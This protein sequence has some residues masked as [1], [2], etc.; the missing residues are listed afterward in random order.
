MKVTYLDQGGLGT[1]D[2]HCSPYITK[3]GRSRR[4]ISR[5]KNYENMKR[6]TG[7]HES[8]NLP[9]IRLSWM[10]Q[11][12]GSSLRSEML[13]VRR[14]TYNDK[15]CLSVVQCSLSIL[16]TNDWHLITSLKRF[17]LWAIITQSIVVLLPALSSRLAM[18]RCDHHC[19]SEK[20]PGFI[21]FKQCSR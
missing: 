8:L 9:S 7:Y 4:A 21:A 3:L 14:F 6:S 5:N 13:E 20:M 2:A 10:M 16:F 17:P 15:S 1:W 19:P 12:G 18:Q 11:N